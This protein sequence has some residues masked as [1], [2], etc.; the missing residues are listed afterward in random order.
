M[1]LACRDIS[2]LD[3]LST[4]YLA[5]VI[6]QVRRRCLGELGVHV[7]QVLLR[8]PLTVHLNALDCSLLAG[9]DHCA[10]FRADALLAAAVVLVVVEIH[11]LLTAHPLKRIPLALLGLHS[12]ECACVCRRFGLIVLG[13]RAARRDQE[14]AVLMELNSTVRRESLL[15][16]LSLQLQS[17]QGVVCLGSA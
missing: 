10:I 17:G 9:R 12:L 7:D 2:S 5:G 3:S 15:T 8:T 1:V 6:A 14:V 13:S 11:V 16:S 4:V